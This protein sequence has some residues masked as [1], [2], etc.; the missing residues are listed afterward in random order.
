M[1]YEIRHYVARPGRREELAR[2]MDRTVI[3]HM[4]SH[5][6]AVVG[7]YQD[8]EREDDYVWIRGFDDQEH[9][10][11]TLA[12]AYGAPAWTEEMRPMVEGLMDASLA[13]VDVVSPTATSG[14]A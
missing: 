8:L 2:Y 10:S 6:M 13:H 7:S 12:T 5:G 3:P 4:A 11:A 1:I 9:R 14:A